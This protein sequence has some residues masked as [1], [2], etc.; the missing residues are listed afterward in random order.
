MIRMRDR[1]TWQ[2]RI[3][4]ALRS[5]ADAGYQERVWVRGQGPESDS[6]TGAIC[7]LFN[8]YGVE[9][10]L[11]ACFDERLL[12]KH[13]REALQ[14]FAVAAKQFADQDDDRGDAARSATAEWRELRAVAQRTLESFAAMGRAGVR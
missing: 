6:S 4:E 9:G 1:E 8:D 3:L 10:F 7:R 11:A 2:T 5:L 13:R 12:S 14:T